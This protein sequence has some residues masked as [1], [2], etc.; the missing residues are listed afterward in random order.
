MIF[1]SCSKGDRVGINTP[2]HS[3]YPI[4]QWATA[5]IGAILATI[6]PTYAPSELV[7][8]LRVSTDYNQV[9]HLACQI[10]LLICF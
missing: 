3:I 10:D 7:N 8:V 1:Y 2:N 9:E 6:N 4:L 5:K